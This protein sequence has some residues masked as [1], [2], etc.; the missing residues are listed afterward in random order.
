MPEVRDRYAPSP[1]GALH[2]GGARTALFNYLFARQHR[3]QFL[4]RIEDTD[5]VRFKE[6]SQA[7]IEEG[8]R[9][10][11]IT[12]DEPP[13]V[14]STRKPVYQEAAEVLLA[15]GAAYRCF[16]TPERLNEMRA[17]QRARKEPE[18]YDRRCRAIPPDEARRRAEAGERNVIRQ[19]MP[20]DG[21]TTLHDLVMGTVSFQNATLDDHVL[22][23]SDGFPTYH[24]AFAVDDH[25]S[26]ISH[27]IR[28][29]GWLP[30]APKHLLLFQAFHWD[31]PAFA[32]VPLVLGAD[33]K[34]LAKRHGAKD[35]LEYRDAG[36]LP[37]A[38]VNFIAFLGW[39]P[40]TT[41][42]ILTIDQL[43]EKF[44]I[45]KIQPSP[46]IA[47]LERLDWLNGQFI[48]R[49]QPEELARR[50]AERMP[51]VTVDELV[52]LV[53]LIQ[54]RLRTMNEAREMLQFFF[55]EPA[56]YAQKQMVPKARDRAQTAAALAEVVAALESVP[57][58]T[59]EAVEPALRSTAERL[60][61]PAKDLF[62]TLRVAITGRTVT[63]PL[64]ESMARLGKSRVLS[65]L[66]RASAAVRATS[67]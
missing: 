1:T 15:S 56:D 46:A 17:E 9:W 33:K 39:S 50:I 64:I 7:L 18:R 65:R 26:R 4:L 10:L 32:H 37:E 25:A 57:D 27:V 11:G 21:T 12:W 22:L 16:C 61:W 24:L 45:D 36:Y 20:L 30:S 60:G 52:P 31:A 58:W 48:R 54:E 2:L 49:L 43:I 44:A 41:E 35:V 34:P 53:P 8:L 6:G 66:E 19:A 40:G 55:E 59:V 42:D 51:G 63:P 13:I 14:Q 47:N 5:R 23:K 3:G 67:A 29:D 62:M 38:V 28:G